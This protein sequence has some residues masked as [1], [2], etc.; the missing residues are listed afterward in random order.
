MV[1]WLCLSRPAG[2][3]GI[4][5]TLA[6]PVPSLLLSAGALAGVIVCACGIFRHF[7]ARQQGIFESHTGVENQLGYLLQQV[8]G[9]P[10]AVKIVRI[11]DMADMILKNRKA[12]EKKSRAYFSEM[13]EVDRKENNANTTVSLSQADFQARGIAENLYLHGGFS[14]LSGHGK[15]AWEGQ[16]TGGKADGRGI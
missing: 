2:N 1:V 15:P 5:D 12:F 7:A 3:A 4:L 13:F 11:Y 6:E 14:G 8:L 10:K 9:D 16:H